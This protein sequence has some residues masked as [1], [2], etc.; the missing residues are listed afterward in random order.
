MKVRTTIKLVAWLAKEKPIFLFKNNMEEWEGKDTSLVQEDIFG[1]TGQG[2]L[3]FL[4][5]IVR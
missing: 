1:L 3:T 2:G 5:Y 4:G